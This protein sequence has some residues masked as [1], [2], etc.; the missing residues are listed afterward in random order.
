MVGS[1]AE[2]VTLLSSGVTAAA[3]DLLAEHTGWLAHHREIAFVTALVF[4]RSGRV[5]EAGCAVDARAVA[6]PMFR[7]DER[8]AFGW[9]GSPSWYRN[10]RAASPIALTFRRAD[11]ATGLSALP[12]GSTDIGGMATAACLAA[13]AD[14]RRGL[15]NPHGWVHYGLEVPDMPDFDASVGEDPFFHPAFASVS[16]L[17]LKAG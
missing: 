7:G 1:D 4:D 16:P 10:C 17:T 13:V 3:G 14:G 11:L 15:V 6:H 8:T 2:T 9:F 5:M 12:P